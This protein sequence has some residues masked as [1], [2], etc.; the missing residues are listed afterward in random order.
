LK[1]QGYH[2]LE[3]AD[4]L[5]ALKI[6]TEFGQSRIDL[7]LTDVVMPKIGGKELADKL[8][9]DRPGLKILFASGYTD[10]AIVRQGIL[11]KSIP[12]IQK[13]FSPKTLV[14][15]VREVLDQ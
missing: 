14:K 10:E 4:G 7:L 9:T 5:D 6:A 11:D 3:A 2:L 12:F 8:K 15:K 13:P 1:E